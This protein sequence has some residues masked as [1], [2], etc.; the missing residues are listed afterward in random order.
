MA[1]SDSAGRD[2]PAARAAAAVNDLIEVREGAMRLKGMLQEQ[3]S[4]F[5][6]LMDGILN[7]LS[8]ALS[9]LDTGCTAGA[10]ASG[11]SDGV[12]RARAESSTGRTRKRSFSRR[13]ERSSG[14]R[15]TD[16]LVD[17]HIWR[18]YGQKEIQN[19]T[20][21]R[22][23]YRCTHK[24]DQGCNAKR[25]V[26]I[27]ETHPIKYAVTYYGEHTCKAPSNTPMIIVPASG[28]RADNLVSF[29]PTLPQLLPATTQLSSSWCTSVDD[30]FSSSSDPFVQ[31]DELAVIVGSAGKT[32]STVGS[33]PDYSGSGI[34]DM[35]RGGTGSF[36]S[37]PS[38]L[39]FVVGSL[40]SIVD[41]DFFQFDP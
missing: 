37:S 25:Q 27:C 12:I 10:S 41:D 7:K 4:G 17:G 33:V 38:S 23:Y 16:T 32:S 2:L 36:A 28:D 22:S 15:V 34:G 26:Q 20:H 6:E 21:P 11:A 19:S 8:S 29:A 35:A 39:G 18:K 14:K 3:S 31:A 40:G 5:A 13:L 30:V 9:A 24:S 1:S